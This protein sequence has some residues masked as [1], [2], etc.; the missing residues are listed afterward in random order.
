MRMQEDLSKRP[1]CMK[2]D[3]S[4]RPCIRKRELRVWNRAF[5]E[6]YIHTKRPTYECIYI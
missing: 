2:R 6:T 5:K 4:K 3:L 1:A